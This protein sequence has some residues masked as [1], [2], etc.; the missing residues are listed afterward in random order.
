MYVICNYVLL[1]NKVF[2]SLF[3]LTPDY[4]GLSLSPREKL[5]RLI[6]YIPHLSTEL[7]QQKRTCVQFYF[8]SCYYH[9]NKWKCHS[10][11]KQNNRILCVRLSVCLSVMING[12]IIFFLINWNRIEPVLIL[13]WTFLMNTKSLFFFKLRLFFNVLISTYINRADMFPGIEV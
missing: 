3:K 2:I 7:S 13:Q 10:C 9:S 12:F 4:G 6:E 8:F 11:G 5:R 1:G